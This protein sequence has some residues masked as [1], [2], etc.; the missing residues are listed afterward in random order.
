MD[1]FDVL[2][3]I[4]KRKMAFMHAGVNENEA[5]IKA[6]FYVSKDYHIPLLDIK[7]LLGVRFI[8]TGLVENK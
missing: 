7:K 4:S 2:T 3:A 5:L 8:P 1:I 6:E